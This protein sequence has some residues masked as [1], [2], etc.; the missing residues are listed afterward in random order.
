M[1]YL[2]SKMKT[3]E[4]IPDLERIS[5]AIAEDMRRRFGG[6]SRYPATGYFGEQ[7]EQILVIES[8]CTPADWLASSDHLHALMR[9]LGSYLKQESI[10]CSLDGKMALV[11]PGEDTVGLSKVLEMLT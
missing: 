4:D 5:D 2:P 8:Y 7:K 9:A 3:G 6:A 1:V 11:K 10:A